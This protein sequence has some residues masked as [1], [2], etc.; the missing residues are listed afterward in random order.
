[1]KAEPNRSRSEW[2]G[3]SSVVTW[4]RRGFLAAGAL[5][6]AGCSGFMKG[7]EKE[8]DD[9]A[10]RA[11]AAEYFDPSRP[12]FIGEI[13]GVW[14]TGFTKVE[15]VALV[16][17]L[18]G[19]GSAPPA[20]ELRRQLMNEMK[21]LD[22]ENPNQVLDGLDTSLVLVRG[23]MPPGIQK[24]ETYD[25]EVFVPRRSETKSLR[26]GTLMPTRLTTAQEVGS[27][28]KKGHLLSTARGPILVDSVFWE[29]DETL[30]M[31]G[32]ILGGGVAQQARPLGLFIRDD[33]QSVAVTM[34]VA[35]AINRRFDTYKD[36]A[37]TGV[38]TPKDNKIVELLVPR[39]YRHNLGRYLQVVRHINYNEAPGMRGQ[40]LEKLTMEIADPLTA[41]SAAAKLEAIGVEGQPILLRTLGHPDPEMRFL[42]A[43]ALAYQGKSEAAPILGEIAV[44]LPA[45]RWHAITAL[46]GMDDVEAGV[47]LAALL[48][49][50]EMETRYAAFRAMLVR[51]PSDPTIA[52]RSI[53]DSFRLH[54]IVTNGPPAI[55]F[56]R[57]RSAEVVVFGHDQRVAENFLVVTP[58]LNVQA[59]GSDQVRISK[60]DAAAGDQVRICSARVEE[61]IRAMGLLGVSYGDLL[62]HFRLAAK[63]GM[64]AGDFAIH[65]MPNPN[66]RYGRGNET[67]PVPQ[68][69]LP[70]LFVD[71]SDTG[72]DWKETNGEQPLT[73]TI[74]AL[75]PPERP[76][77]FQR[78][79]S[80]F[81]G[82]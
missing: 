63:S 46:A 17:N 7:K 55:H 35:T 57:V 80:W 27:V 41:M 15:A 72:S 56:S 9:E 49:H 74:D 43:E 2:H 6:L 53:G 39:S 29:G 59:I 12:R 51:S 19:T 71:P 26:G 21:I 30:E 77:F 36:G 16:T 76:N 70:E 54:T 31:H 45:F 28:V 78:M 14:G 1:M 37:K 50:P 69:E 79:G 24:G 82:G 60:F 25:V 52:G 4:S 81:T 8:E 44:N 73:E 23:L 38:A 75:V 22:V 5:S 40:L 3:P 42:A 68:Q 58:G 13:A 66:R 18:K 62:G 11:R 33:A 20:D 65:A 61:I 64:L 47:A 32:R 34:R 48:D 67:G 10:A